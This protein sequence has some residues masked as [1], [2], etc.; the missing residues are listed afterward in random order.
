MKVGS[1][2]KI[3]FWSLEYYFNCDYEVQALCRIVLR[4][5]GTKMWQFVHSRLYTEQD[6][7]CL[8]MCLIEDVKIITK[9]VKYES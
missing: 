4:E 7:D 6:A 3:K 9:E 5:D 8:S 2:R 1:I